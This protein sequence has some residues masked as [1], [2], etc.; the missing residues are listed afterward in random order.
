MT[1]DFPIWANLIYCDY[2]YQN[3][4]FSWVD[5]YWKILND[6]SIFMA[7]TDD[8]TMAQ[9]KLKLD[10]MPGAIHLNTCIMVQE[11]GGTSKRAFP[12]KHD[13]IFIYANGK[14]YKF[15]SDRIQIPKVTAGTNFDK[16]G[17]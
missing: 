12:K 16:K 14:D 17:T 10:S 11:W 7:Q 5:K 4:D 15:Y 3:T 1:F 8:S 13:Y 2:I 6:N 9:I